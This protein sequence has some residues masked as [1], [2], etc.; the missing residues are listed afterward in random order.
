MGIYFSFCFFLPV[1]K[2]SKALSYPLQ[3]GFVVTF[4]VSILIFFSAC[5][6]DFTVPRS[7]AILLASLADQRAEKLELSEVC[8]PV[9]PSAF[10]C[11]VCPRQEPR[12]VTVCPGSRPSS[13]RSPDLSAVVP[14]Q[15]KQ[16]LRCGQSISSV[17]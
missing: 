5:V 12:D 1:A 14:V 7:S 6:L 8:V 2:I 17:L 9:L 15:C 10:L 13:A 16:R 3:K 4:L 11:S